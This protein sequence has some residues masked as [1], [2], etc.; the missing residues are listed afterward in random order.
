MSD[1]YWLND[2]ALTT[3]S[4]G[5]LDEGIPRE[6]LRD[7]AIERVRVICDTAEKTLGRKGFADKLF[8]YVAKGWVSFSSPVWSNYGIERGLPISCNNSHVDDTSGSIL[9]KTAE[10]GMMT[11]FG[12]GTSAYY[13]DVRPKGSP[14][15]GGGETLGPVHFMRLV[16]E[17][18]DVIS[19]ANVR[20]GNCAAYLPVDHPDIW[21]FLDLIREDLSGDEK[22]KAV[23][24]LSI[25]VCI[26]DKWMEE[27]LAEAPG[28]EKRK[29]MARII[30]KRRETGF[31]YIFFTDNANKGAPQAYV[32]KGMRINSSNLC[33]EIML[34]STTD[35][36]FV[37][38]L[39]SVNLVHYLEWKDTDLIETM[40]AFLDAVLTEYIDKIEALDDPD[41]R[42][43]MQAPLKFSRRWRAL[44]LGVLGWH[45]FL[46]SQN[47]AFS[48][49]EARRYN[50]EIFRLIQARSVAASQQLANE[51]GEPEGLIGYGM[52]NV[53]VNAIAPT[54]TSSIILGQVSQ[55]IEPFESNYFENDSAKGGFTYRNPHLKKRLA[56]LG[57]DTH[58]VWVDILRHGGSV[59][60]LEFLSDNDRE[61]FKTFGEIS[62][63][64]IVALAA[65]RQPYIDQGQSLNL[66]IHPDTPVKEINA[67]IIEAWQLGL[68]SLYYHRSTNKAQEYARG[69]MTCTA[70]EA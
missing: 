3:L 40:I 68:K 58:E 23:H 62:Q 15:S 22:K 37:C 61:V 56:E 19:Q 60:H 21:E 1:F 16:A 29:L 8:G 54:T 35:E 5:Y 53:T 67:L 33:T 39:S 9:L 34:A 55:S 26:S 32:D 45:S 13:G 47:L 14:I 70:C 51:F 24:H 64:D 10:I 66:K 57:K 63:G 17:T 6:K 27:Y 12:A 38:N 25:G 44:G 4:R 59:Q 69:L 43:L 30:R 65:Q 41:A 49:W 50:A 20:R 31:P 36:S 46:Q 2:A 7:A 48:S 42:M 11:K 18:T 28:G 52:R